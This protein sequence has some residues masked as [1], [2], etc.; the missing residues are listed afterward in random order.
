MS[1]LKHCLKHVPPLSKSNIH[2]WLLELDSSAYLLKSILSEDEKQR[3]HQFLDQKSKETFI[4]CRGILRL[5][6]SSYLRLNP[7]DIE[8]H[9]NSYGKPFVPPL[10]NQQDIQFNLSHSQDIAA[11]SFSQYQTI[12]VDIENINPTL[13]PNELSSL[14]MTDLELEDFHKFHQ[15]EKLYAFY[16][17]WTQKEAI[18]KAQGTGFQKPPNS[19]PGYLTPN[20]HLKNVQIEDWTL[21]SFTVKDDYSACICTKDIINVHTIYLPSIISLHSA[22]QK[23]KPNFSKY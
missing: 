11:F 1:I 8:L 13:D 21:N 22:M 15:S 23:N 7:Q 18:L 5:L 9:Y 2:L 14:I 20:I 12:G 3:A 6:L 17:L 19:I 4:A 10:Q 16:H